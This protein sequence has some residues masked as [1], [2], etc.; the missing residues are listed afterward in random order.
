MIKSIFLFGIINKSKLESM[1]CLFYN[2]EFMFGCCW[3]RKTSNLSASDSLLKRQWYHSQTYCMA[4]KEPNGEPTVTPSIWLWNLRSNMK[5]ESEVA[6]WK[7]FF[8]SALVILKPGFISKSKSPAISIV[9]V[10][11]ILLNNLQTS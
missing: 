8:R 6:H 2:W 11:R 3:F 10:S 4:R 7:I 5:C 1:L 9:S